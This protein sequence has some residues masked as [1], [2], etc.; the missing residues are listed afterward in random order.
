MRN[1]SDCLAPSLRAVV[2]EDCPL[3]GKTS[4]RSGV[5]ERCHAALDGARLADGSFTVETDGEDIRAA[6][7]FRYRNDGVKS[8]LFFLKRRAD[9]DVF[10][11]AA[12]YLA[13]AVRKLPLPEGAV[14]VNVPRGRRAV[15]KYGFDHAKRL[16]ARAA[17]LCGATYCRAVGRLPFGA[18]QKKLGKSERESNLAGRFYVRPFAA[19]RLRDTAAFVIVDDVTTTGTSIRET[20]RALRARFADVPVYAAVLARQIGE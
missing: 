10:A 12:V 7:V 5:C 19:F 1:G 18:E 16:A 17:L 11:D 9:A 14:F 20:A 4:A 13:A 6:A 15:M 3:C 2:R 8:L